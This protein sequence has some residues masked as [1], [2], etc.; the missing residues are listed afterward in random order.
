MAGLWERAVE[1]FNSR[2]ARVGVLGLGYAGL[3]LTC[4]FAEAG[5]E[6]IGFDVDRSKI[7]K[8]QAGQSYIGHI[9]SER[10]AAGEGWSF[11]GQR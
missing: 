3:P 4:C 6:T 7:Q 9:P 10:I 2:R 5:Y 8:L 1:K 11:A